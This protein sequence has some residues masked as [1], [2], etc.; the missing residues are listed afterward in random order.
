MKVLL[1]GEHGQLARCLQEEVASL[2]DI[3]LIAVRRLRRSAELPIS[4]GMMHELLQLHQPSAI[5][6]TAAFHDLA[7]CEA[8]FDQAYTANAQLVQTLINAIELF[9]TPER[10]CHL[11]TL[12]TDYVFDGM[13]PTPHGPAPQTAPYFPRH[14]TNPLNNYG[15]TKRAA[16]LI[17][18]QS[19]KATVVRTSSLF[20]HHGSVGKGGSNFLLGMLKKAK[21][22]DPIEV[23]DDVVMSPTYTP[24]LARALLA[25][26]YSS[27]TPPDLMH[28]VCDGPPLSWYQFARM[29][30]ECGEV[31]V[32]DR[33]VTKRSPDWPPRPQYSALEADPTFHLG[34]VE[35]ALGDYFAKRDREAIS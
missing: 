10:A 15:R 33:L 24:W 19:N 18:S 1:I 29:I 22:N 30:F 14:P 7:A 4:V 3:R 17:C 21:G 32:G 12:S 9:T 5:I 2:Q 35:A 26:V 6:N 23:D 13:Q 31:D 34:T 27:R 16:E 25:L 8:D 28:L 20:S 11:Y